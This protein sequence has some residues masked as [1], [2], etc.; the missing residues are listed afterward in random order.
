MSGKRLAALS[1]CIGLLAVTTACGSSDAT[2][3]VAG[4]PNVIIKVGSA[5][6]YSTLDPAQAYD[7]GAWTVY[8]NVYQGLMSYRPGSNVP[9]EDAAQSCGYTDATDETYK[10]VLRPNMT[11]SNGDPLDAAAVKYSIDRVIKINDPNG[12]VA[13]LSTSI[14]SVET[15]GAD[16]VVFHLKYPDATMPARLCSGAASIIDPKTVPADKEAATDDTGV[17]GSGRYKID[18]VT[19]DGSGADKLPTEVK[20]SLNPN[21][22]GAATNP[23]NSGIDLRYYADQTGTK[24]ALDHNDV[25]AVIADLNA[26]DVVSMQ[27]NQQLGTGLQVDSGPGGGIHM[28]ALNTTTGV[29]SK[30]AVRR[31]VAELVNRDDIVDKAFHHTVSAAYTIVPSG[32]T[33]ATGSFAVYG[34]QPTSAA[35]VREQLKKA[36]VSLP[37]PFTFS[38]YSKGD[39]AIQQESALIK[40]ELEADGL[41]KVTLHDYLTYAKL[42]NAVLKKPNFDA[43]TLTW[44]SDYLDIDDYINPLVGLHN[45]VFNGYAAPAS[46]ISSGLAHTNREDAKTDYAEIQKDVAK[47]VP[48]VPL[49]ESSQFAAT[50]ADISGVP[51][52][53]DSSGIQRWWMIGKNATS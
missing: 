47:D 50:Q 10:C 30:P 40:K 16:T 29:F 20:L 48:L 12:P 1:G 26:S 24:K 4:A 31:A 9:Q 3:P 51:L 15:Q 14:K 2:G 45:T 21:Y 25:D 44:Y 34:R 53:M 46:L 36:G 27:Q 38:F 42:S 28:L 19:F 17:I 7:N 8:Y 41:F 22:K 39:Q 49:W 37:I 52:T 13:I 43:Y 18:S 6:P 32:I 35:T 5:N 23:R 33:N 11:F